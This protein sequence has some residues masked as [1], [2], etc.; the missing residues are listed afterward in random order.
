[1][2]NAWNYNELIREITLWCDNFFKFC[3]IYLCIN[4]D[5]YEIFRVRFLFA[6]S[7]FIIR[8]IRFWKDI[9]SCINI[10]SYELF[11]VR[12]H[13]RHRLIKNV[14]DCVTDEFYLESTYLCN[15]LDADPYL[16]LSIKSKQ[17]GEL[18]K[19]NKQSSIN[20]IKKSNKQNITFFNILIALSTYAGRLIYTEQFIKGIWV[21]C[22]NTRMIDTIKYFKSQE[23]E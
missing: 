8:Q 4:M 6:L 12:L 10:V 20:E 9:F 16:F 13:Y 11:R 17:Y 15:S 1:M 18:S 5:C 2:E 22:S 19:C 23:I 14:I 3:F 7:C 21:Y